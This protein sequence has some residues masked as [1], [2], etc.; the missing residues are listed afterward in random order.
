MLKQLPISEYQKRFFLEWIISPNSCEY[1]ESLVFKV[2]G[3][4]SKEKLKESCSIFM[5]EHDVMHARYNFDGS[6]CY[7]DYFTIDE[8]YQEKIL[9]KSINI[10]TYIQNLLSTPFDLTKGKLVKFYLLML[11][12][13]VN[14]FVI[15]AHHIILDGP[16]AVILIK[17]IAENYNLITSNQK[18]LSGRSK[19]FIQAVEL[20]KAELLKKNVEEAKTFWQN[21]LDNVPLVVEL[22]AKKHIINGDNSSRRV[23]CTLT[24]EELLGFKKL[25]KETRSTG[26]LVLSA[27][28]GLVLSKYCNQ[29]QFAIS[30]PINMRPRGFANITGCFVNN[31]SLIINLKGKETLLDVIKDMIQQIVSAEGYEW[32]SLTDVIH[33]QRK[34]RN[35]FDQNYLNVG[36]VDTG[37][38]LSTESVCF[39]G[40]VLNKETIAPNK[41]GIYEI[42]LRYSF[43]SGIDLVFEYAP[44]VLDEYMAS[45]FIDAIKRLVIT[46]YDN[47]DSTLSSTNLLGKEEYKKIIYDWN[48]TEKAYPE[49]K[50][51]HQLF[52]EQVERTPNNMAVVY[53]GQQLTYKELNNNANW[54]AKYIRNTYKN[55]TEKELKPDTLVVLC[56][57]RSLEILVGILGIL[58]AGC[59][60]VPIDPSCPQERMK[61]ILADISSKIIVTN[62]KTL[63]RQLELKNKS[64]FNLK[65]DKELH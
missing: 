17:E 14:Y 15:N 58:K 51:I 32:Y 33:D 3:S 55:R 39:E 52:E 38:D 19:S 12:A 44:T 46:C 1:N 5:R 48:A 60:Y 7:Y 40:L 27:I 25:V 2:S 28:Y 9:D 11:D 65:H 62:D 26:F 41:N 30:Y 18:I 63:N 61:H 57:D 54:L 45:G 34:I 49:N 31:L 35:E 24:H 59:A 47:K 36:I 16:A 13:E 6:E 43:L 42:C 21:Q 22:A 37:A 53:E 64:L 10:K 4:L 23:Y 20:E 56:L 29:E 50:T 8:Y